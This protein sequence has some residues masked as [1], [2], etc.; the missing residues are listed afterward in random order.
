MK[1]LGSPSEPFLG[2][3]IQTAHKHFFRSLLS[4]SP[5]PNKIIQAGAFLTS[6]RKVVGSN[7]N[8]DNSYP[9]VSLHLPNDGDRVTQFKS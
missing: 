5:L 4:D 3:R 7:L 6:I 9:K 1:F 8:R 2:Q